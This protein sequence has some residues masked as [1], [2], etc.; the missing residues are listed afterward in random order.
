MEECA[1]CMEECEWNLERQREA[2]LARLSH[3]D[4]R[5]NFGSECRDSFAFAVVD[6][7][8]HLW[9]LLYVLPDVSNQKNAE[10]CYIRE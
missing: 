3:Q 10:D 5:P 9:V 1:E 8:L 4:R 2:R 6:M 7:H